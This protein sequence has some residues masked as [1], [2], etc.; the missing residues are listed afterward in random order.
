MRFGFLVAGFTSGADAIAA[1]GTGR[2]DLVILDAVLPDMPLESFCKALKAALPANTPPLVAIAPDGDTAGRLL[3]GN[4]SIEDCI[5][6][7]FTPHVL[8]ARIAG[9]MTGLRPRSSSTRVSASGGGARPALSWSPA[10]RRAMVDGKAVQLAPIEHRILGIMLS[11][12]GT[13]FSR[14]ELLAA[15]SGVGAEEVSPRSV[16]V[17]MVAL[18]RKLGPASVYIQTVRGSGYRYVD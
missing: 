13:V 2:P 9:V 5:V 10:S 4:L 17:A 12:K 11:R 1:A 3:S 14:N 8:V 7:P 6:K 16:D 18:R 15:V